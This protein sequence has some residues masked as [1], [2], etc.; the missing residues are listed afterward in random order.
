M[1]INK[2][3]DQNFVFSLAELT[4]IILS[5]NLKSEINTILLTTTKIN[6]NSPRSSGE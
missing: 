4:T 6:A 1:I 3:I 2:L 5:L